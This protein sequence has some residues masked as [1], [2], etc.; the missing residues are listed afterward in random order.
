LN[1]AENVFSSR[2]SRESVFYSDPA[3]E[4]RPVCD[5]LLLIHKHSIQLS[6]KERRSSRL[7]AL[8]IVHTDVKKFNG[9][10]SFLEN[11]SATSRILRNYEFRQVNAAVIS[12]EYTVIPEALY[13][14]GDEVLYFRK[15]F[16]DSFRYNI[17]CRHN[18]DNHLHIA[19]GAEPELETELK[20]LFQD[21]QI[22]HHSQALLAGFSIL[23]SSDDKNIWLQVHRESMDIVV[24]HKR[25]LLFI[26]SFQWQ[27]NEDILYYLLYVCEQL[28]IGTDKCN[29]TITGEVI[30][31][32][33]LFIMLYNHFSH[34]NFP[35]KSSGMS[36]NTEDLPF[37]E[38]ALMYNFSLCE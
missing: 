29:L 18:P 36:L 6:L 11:I 37:H 28:E 3:L 14:Q 10:R 9:W 31:G 27:T 19:F 26:N 12:N 13:R 33:S 4:A 7:L 15:N 22:S 32:S 38:Y 17:H 25:K 1:P 30:E 5:L 2:T 21:P 35:A 23:P 24:S 20:H 8:E 34:L 16:S